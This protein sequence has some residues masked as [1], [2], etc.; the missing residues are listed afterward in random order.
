METII[1]EQRHGNPIQLPQRNNIVGGLKINR[2]FSSE[3]QHPYDATKWEFRNIKATDDKGN[4]IL[5]RANVEVPAHWGPSAVRF[6]VEKYMFGSKPENPEYESS[7]KH[8]FDR[9]ANTYT[10]WGWQ[11][12]YFAELQDA[13]IFN[14]EIKAMLV[15]QIWAPNSPVW[16]NIGHWEQWRWGRPDLRDLF[17]NKGNKAYHAKPD[18][19]G[20]IQAIE[21]EHAYANPQASACFLTQVSDSMETKDGIDGILQHLCTEGRVFASGSGIGINIGKLRSSFEPIAGKGV[22]SG[23][24]PFN[25]GWDR[26]AGAIKSGGKCL[27]PWQKVYTAGGPVEVQRLAQY[28]MPFIILSYDPTKGQITTKTAVAW[29]EG[30]KKVVQITTN[31]GIFALSEDHPLRTADSKIVE[32]GNLK[33]GTKLHAGII[34]E[35]NEYN[36]LPKRPIVHLQDK[37]NTTKTLIDIALKDDNPTWTPK[38]NKDYKKLQ[39]KLQKR[40]K[41]HKCSLIVTDITPIGEMEVYDIGVNCPSPDDKTAASGHNFL[42]WSNT[43]NK[44]IGAGIFVLNTRRAARMVIMPADHPDIFQFIAKK[45]DQ[46][47][48]ARI[49]LHDHNTHIKL[50]EI[51]REKLINGTPQ[52]KTAASIILTLPIANEESYS[53]KMD[54]L[55]YGETLSDQNANHSVTFKGEF[56]KTL[57]N[58]GEYA[59]RWITDPN[60]I[61]SKYKPNDILKQIAESIYKCG[62]PGIHNNDWINLWNPVKTN[63]DIDT[64][65]PCSEF[66]HLNETSCNLSSFNIARFIDKHGKFDAKRLHAG[67]RLAV[68]VAD[69]NIEHGGFPTPEIAINTYRYRATGIGYAN[70]GGL[71][72]SLGIPYDSDDG[73]HIAAHI[74]NLLSAAAWDAS[75]E[76]ASELGSYEAFDKTKKDLLEVIN[77]HRVASEALCSTKTQ[78]Q[79]SLNTLFKTNKDKLPHAQGLDGAS[80]LT[81]F[82]KNFKTPIS[83]K[84]THIIQDTHAHATALWNSNCQA[85]KYRNSF[86]TCLAPTG[87][88]SAPL[89]CYDAGTTSAEP[90]YTLVKYKQLSGG[91]SV[92]MF[93]TLA[94]EGLRT[95]GYSEA[96]IREA[97]L[98]VAG[99]EGLETAAKTTEEAVEHL[100]WM[101]KPEDWGPVRLAFIRLKNGTP[102]QQVLHALKSEQNG[103]INPDAQLLL[104]GEAHM[105]NIPWLKKEHL[106]VF[107]CSATSGNSTR[108]I[109]HSGHILMLGAIQPFLS[110]ATSKTVNLPATATVEEIQQC[111]IDA[112]E[113]GIKCIAAYK[114]DSKA[115]AVF[116]VDTPETRKRQASYIWNQLVETASQSIEEIITQASKPKRTR[117]K[118]RRWAQII[119]FQVDGG[120]LDG[121]FTFGIYPNGTCGE[122]FATIGQQGSFAGGVVGTL[123]KQIS[124]SLQFGMPLQRIIDSFQGVAFE[125]SGFCIVGDD[126]D[127]YGRCSD[128]KACSSISDL[129][130]QILQWLFPKENGYKI[131]NLNSDGQTVEQTTEEITNQPDTPFHFVTGMTIAK[132][133]PQAHNYGNARECQKCHKLA[134]IPDGK[135]WVCTNCGQ[136]EGGCGA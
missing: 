47:E 126:T 31:N 55:L 64:S 17:R 19:A 109:H 10:I 68:I 81:A 48:I 71:L 5:D 14:E 113:H 20:V 114:A 34:T 133:T 120:K 49:V 95:L 45:H 51:A 119:K 134:L 6:T 118:G 129:L 84:A 103:E 136:K 76:L 127:P 92:K 90:D 125:P 96:Q 1:L 130:A 41:K 115:N 43:N 3:D 56:W 132:E 12:G 4:I 93:N 62:E 36:K 23:P 82:A 123:C 128:I 98:E 94:L 75:R 89:G 104:N 124:T 38:E 135:C 106:P 30:I 42:I 102:T 85:A 97:A 16:F 27:A 59:T 18:N 61:Q 111:I 107:D 67:I 73:R 131:R 52:E 39:N 91:G 35:D 100:N 108:S 122:V 110:G 11:E 24:L 63:G 26:M 40:P 70:L 88:I 79:D 60:R 33:P 86:V 54:D 121:H 80:M 29:K 83:K 46:D 99:I 22:S 66:L 13:L 37:N 77:L 101:P 25:S 69:L 57:E 32:A 9:I 117:V 105:E 15:N 28:D 21:A 78:N 112:H 8:T 7:L 65:N 72:M 74:T 2:T 87:T 44:D 53:P 50:R 58:N 116:Y